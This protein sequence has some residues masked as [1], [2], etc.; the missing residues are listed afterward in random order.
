MKPALEH[1]PKEK[2]ASFVVKLFDYNYYPTPWHYHPEYE[3]VM[4]TESTGKRFIG[5]HIS[6]FRPGNL[7]LLG[8]NIPHTYRNDD[9]YYEQNSSLRAKSIVIHFTEASLGND[10][11]QLP[12]ARSL[13]KL[14]ERSLYGLDIYGATNQK[15]S[16]KLYDI[17]SLQ[18]MKRWIGLVDILTDLAESKNMS[19]ITKTTHVGY[20]E[21]ESKRLCSV[22][23]WVTTNFENEITLSEAAQIAQMNE[24]AFSRFFSLRTRKTFSG[25]VQELR[26]QKAAKLLVEN[27]MTITQV[28]YECGYNNVSNFNRQ[29]L[30]HYQMN[31][32]KYRKTF[33]RKL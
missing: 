29:F 10:F 17:V 32:M 2:D 31:P 5:D 14:F 12:E 23:D 28:C 9:K 26:L 18:G 22:F 19:P 16:K 27:D 6:D 1:L 13:Y 8:P 21:K 24:N 15:V 30:N 33:L 3:I 4:V 25:F 11:L 7:A 20:N